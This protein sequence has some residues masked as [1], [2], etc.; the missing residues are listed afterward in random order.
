MRAALAALLVLVT[1][2]LTFAQQPATIRVTTRIVPLPTMVTDGQGRL[3]PDLGKDAF[4]ILDNGKPQEIALFENTVQPFTVVV[5]LDFSLSMALRIDL[6]KEAA[7]SF[8]LRMLPADKGQVGSFSDRIQFSGNFTNNRDRL[9]AS[10][11]D[12]DFGNATKLWDAVDASIATLEPLEGRR[13]VLVFTDGDDTASRASLGSVRER[14]QRDDI[15]IYAIGLRTPRSAGGPAAAPD[16]GLRKVADATGGGYF[17]LNNTDDLGSTFT[18]VAQELH[19]LYTI[20]FAP[21]K[22]DGKEHKLIVK[23]NQADQ[24]VRTRGSY[25]AS[26]DR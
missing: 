2:A 15:M 16:A 3:V 18:R 5:M 8:L 4:T 10:L 1:A 21:Q 14:A 13:V 20:G 19:S 11:R 12:L 9:I 17:E 24:K 26:D 6:L 25:L 7:E 23:T 22:L